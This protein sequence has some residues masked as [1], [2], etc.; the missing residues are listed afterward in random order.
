MDAALNEYDAKIDTKKRITLRGSLFEYYHVTE[1][2]SGE[3]RLEP[4][5]LVPPFHISENSLEMMDQSM[6]N[7][8]NGKVSDP[9]DLSEFED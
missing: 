7:L 4:R 9:I 2:P 6:K 5:E 1:Y 3:I 8:K